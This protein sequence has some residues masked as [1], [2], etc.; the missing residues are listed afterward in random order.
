MNSPN[1]NAPSDLA[2][3]LGKI[4]SGLFIL[5]AASGDNATGMLASWVMQAGFDPPMVTVGVNK[6]RYVLDWLV[7]DAPFAL[8]AVPEGDSTWLRHFG[9]GF[10]PGADAFSG[11]ATEGDYHGAPLIAGAAARLQ[12]NVRGSVDAGDHQVIVAQVAGGSASDAAP[13]VHLRKNGLNY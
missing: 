2:A 13:A 11:I 12:C 9:R 8:H 1:T 7:D 10:E 3:A 5:T 6:K 4:P